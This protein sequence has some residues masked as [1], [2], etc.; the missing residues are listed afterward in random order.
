MSE[1]ERES[2]FTG[3]RLCGKG[4]IASIFVFLLFIHLCI[5]FKPEGINNMLQNELQ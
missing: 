1:G 4:G 2:R 5:T 3:S